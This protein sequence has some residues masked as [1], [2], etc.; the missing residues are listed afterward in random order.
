MPRRPGAAAA[1]GGGGGGGWRRRVDAHA[2]VIPD[3]HLPIPIVGKR[4]VV[5]QRRIAQLPGHVPT[6][7]AADEEALRRLKR[8]ASRRARQVLGIRYERRTA[9]IDAGQRRR[10]DGR[11]AARRH[12]AVQLREHPQRTARGKRRPRAPP[13]RARRYVEPVG[14]PAE[15]VPG[16]PGHLDHLRRFL[17]RDEVEQDVGFARAVADVLLR[18]RQLDDAAEGEGGRILA[19]LRPQIHLRADVEVADVVARPRLVDARIAIDDPSDGGI[20]DEHR[21]DVA[22]DARIDEERPEDLGP[23]PEAHGKGAGEVGDVGVALDEVRAAPIPA[24]RPLTAGEHFGGRHI[25]QSSVA[26][27][28]RRRRS[29][30][31]RGGRRG[32]CRSTLSRGCP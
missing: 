22:I 28:R 20:G 3:P 21:D 29:R 8:E 26:V 27:E 2:G 4:V 23:I 7:T 32:L 31:G 1:G 18:R 12:V 6:Q 24:D 9:P 14:I 16:I 10:R 5:G 30:V 17:A 13:E 19:I 11:R 15:L 25:P